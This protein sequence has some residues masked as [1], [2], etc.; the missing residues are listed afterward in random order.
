MRLAQLEYFIKI[1][2]CGSI[3]KAAQELFMSQPSLT[4]S[5]G[6][7]EHEYNIQLLAR[8]PKGIQLTPQGRE[9]LEY[10]KAAVNAC[11]ALES[12]FGSKQNK[13]IQRLVIASQQFD[14]L[15]PVIEQIYHTC[16]RSTFH[17]DLEET[18]RGSIIAQLEKREA[19]IGLAVLTQHDS[20]KFERALQEKSLEIHT[21]D[22]STV[23]VSMGK[24]SPLYG[25]TNITATEAS[26]HPH[27]VLDTEKNM[28]RE[29]YLNVESQ[30][31]DPSKLIFCNTIGACN[32][33]LQKTDALLYTPKWVLKLLPQSDVHSAPL[34]EADG[35]PFP[36]VN[37]LVWLKRSNEI[38]TPLEE[39]F[40]QLLTAH[41]MAQ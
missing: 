38:F 39:Q 36:D 4:K 17:I 5:I 16:S 34:L 11:Q 26:R 28:R 20:K 23:Y 29:L 35:S 30:H 41:F 13:K 12:N 25:Q 37:R 33:F 9:F 22:R 6:N 31:V 3:T 24:N 14:F 21:L 18:D 40:L 15:Y 2:E 1:A 10:A 19:D 8:T 27:V 7:L 32:Y